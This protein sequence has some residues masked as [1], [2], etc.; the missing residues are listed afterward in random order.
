MVE[1][2]IIGVGAC[3]SSTV[4]AIRD[5]LD[6]ASPCLVVSNRSVA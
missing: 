4:K 6:D 1:W 2:A 3:D 5:S